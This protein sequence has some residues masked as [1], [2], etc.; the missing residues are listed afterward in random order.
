MFMNINISVEDIILIISFILLIIL[1]IYR[2][3]L[4]NSRFA[5]N[6]KKILKTILGI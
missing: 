2:N 1:I 4:T 6:L 5:L 3:R